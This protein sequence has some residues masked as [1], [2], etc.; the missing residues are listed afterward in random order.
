MYNRISLPLSDAPSLA[1]PRTTPSRTFLSCDYVV[2]LSSAHRLTPPGQPINTNLLLS[3]P[4][5]YSFNSGRQFSCQEPR[6]IN[7][8]NIFPLRNNQLT[9]S[10]MVSCAIQY[11]EQSPVR[12]GQYVLYMF[13]PKLFLMI[14]AWKVRALV[15][16]KCLPQQRCSFVFVNAMQRYLC[17][18][19]VQTTSILPLLSP[20][21][22]HG[23][24]CCLYERVV[25]IA[26][27]AC[28][29]VTCVC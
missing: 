17:S 23:V 7:I 12:F 29:K 4:D 1:R 15:V 6:P 9:I 3:C 25:T 13:V 27:R 22:A 28:S 18:L 5:N 10:V 2:S 19:I 20:T 16:E 26:L 21:S 14:D 8:T 24:C 11:P